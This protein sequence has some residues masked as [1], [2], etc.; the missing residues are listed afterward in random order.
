MQT[1]KEPP[2]DLRE[3]EHC[4]ITMTDGIR[5]SARSWLPAAPD[6]AP[7]PAILEYIPYRKR[8]LVRARDERNHP[9]FAAHGYAC[10]RVDMRGSGDS[11]GVM[12]DMYSREELAD[13]I[14]I[15]NWIAGQKWCSGAVG[16]MGT[17]WGGTSSLQAASRRPDALKAIIAVCATNNRF[18]DD[19]HHMGGC[20][21]TDSVEWG[22]ALNTIL[23]AP[24]DPETVGPDWRAMWRKRLASVD[25]PLQNW[26][27][28]ETRDAYWRWG[29][30]D[31]IP[32]AIDCPLLAVGGWADR[33]SN[34]VMHLLA[35]CRA[36]SWGII[37]PWGHHY[38]DGARPGPGIGFQQEALRWWDHWLK[39]IDNGVEQAPQ[40]RFWMQEYQ[41]P[42]DALEYRSGYWSSELAWPS[43]NI[44]EKE[45]FLSRDRLESTRNTDTEGAA[46]PFALKV[47]AAAGDTG[48]FG[49][50]GGLPTD[51]QEDD[52]HCLIFETDPLEAPLEI[53]GS[54]QLRGSLQSD[55]PISTLVARLNDVPPHGEISR[56]TFAVHN[57]ALDENGEPIRQR[58]SDTA[59]SFSLS[60]PNAAYSFDRGHR[61][62]L[63]LSSSYWPLIWPTPAAT[64]ITLHLE[65]TR[66]I[67]QVRAA[68]VER[69]PVIFAKPLAF[70][71]PS[72]NV[73][74]SPS[75]E[76]WVKTD[77]ES[78]SR[79]IYWH[80]PLTCVHFKAIDLEFGY[81]TSAQ[82]S[83]TFDD[84]NSAYTKFEH[85]LQF[86]RED[87]VIEVVGRAELK[88][89]ATT[90][91]LSGSIE[92]RENGATI[93]KRQWSPV[94]PRI[95]S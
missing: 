22:A 28:H 92:V 20:L 86:R 89:T 66:L 74:S 46:V 15:I 52:D 82:Y 49:R 43:A 39:G 7:S 67:L 2:G 34:T 10:V 27:K 4:W 31:E 88:S 78:T 19:I 3:I 79:T 44:T 54:V 60:F 69:D 58:E 50:A 84:P 73:I 40:L 21:L 61:I 25:F 9:Y 80:Q 91:N 68:G 1:E 64:R 13:A 14:E 87:W 8:D 11:E 42:R 30:I 16:M 63:A 26:I 71:V 85:K 75:L 24:P 83:I 70:D 93:F 59:R 45:L 95:Y 35:Q 33:Y 29:A 12:T 17:S 47:G 6:D 5:L 55:R 23:A 18:D 72:I 77:A 76:R 38:P 41:E 32:E 62:R 81:E 57:L 65:R 51:Q 48:Y 90:Y 53:L 94:I 37:G 56:V 36:Q